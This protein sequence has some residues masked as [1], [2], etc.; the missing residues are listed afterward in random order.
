MKT[1]QQL[2]PTI[3]V[4]R[5]LRA[6]AV[7]REDMQEIAKNRSYPADVRLSAKEAVS[8]FDSAV[9]MPVE[10]RNQPGQAARMT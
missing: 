3:Q 10:L 4:H 2:D 9:R 6:V 8:D 1:D 5:L 7:L